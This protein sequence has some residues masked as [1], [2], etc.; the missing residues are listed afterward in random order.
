MSECISFREFAKSNMGSWFMSLYN[1]FKTTYKGMKGALFLIS[2]NEPKI[3]AFKDDRERFKTLKRCMDANTFT[4]HNKTIDEFIENGDVIKSS[5]KISYKIE[6]VKKNSYK[7]YGPN[8][9]E[10]EFT[11]NKIKSNFVNGTYF[12]VAN[13]NNM[14]EPEPTEREKFEGGGEF[15]DDI[16]SYDSPEAIARFNLIT[17]RQFIMNLLSKVKLAKMSGEDITVKWYRIAISLY[18]FIRLCNKD[19]EKLLDYLVD[20]SPM[21]TT[22]N[23]L[24]SNVIDNVGLNVYNQSPSLISNLVIEYTNMINCHNKSVIDSSFSQYDDI[25]KLSKR[26]SESF[27]ESYPL[28]LA[29]SNLFKFDNY[30]NLITEGFDLTDIT[31]DTKLE[32][33]TIPNVQMKSL[34]SVDIDSHIKLLNDYKKELRL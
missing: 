3:G 32:I 22:L 14:I 9:F 15:V 16:D 33:P 26:L 34:T 10:L 6:P 17:R 18:N 8:D 31:I 20:S 25:K 24:L 30:G 2:D 1:C 27:D 29:S 21:A 13:V 12:Y 11:L 28:I 19:K 4:L 7:I 23:I 5:N